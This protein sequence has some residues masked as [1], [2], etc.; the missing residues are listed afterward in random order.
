MLSLSLSKSNKVVNQQARKGRIEGVWAYLLLLQGVW[1]NPHQI[2]DESEFRSVYQ[3]Q[4]S[5]A[6]TMLKC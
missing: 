6:L 1:A 3:L 4:S 2:P 5:L